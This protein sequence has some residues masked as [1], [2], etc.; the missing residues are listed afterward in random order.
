M[1]DDCAD[2]QGG[3]DDKTLTFLRNNVSLLLRPG[4]FPEDHR[5]CSFTI[6]NL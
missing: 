2:S 1:F 6:Y 4:H 5:V 3:A